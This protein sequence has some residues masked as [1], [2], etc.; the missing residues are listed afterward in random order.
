[1]YSGHGYRLCVSACLCIGL[2]DISA[3]VIAFQFVLE[4][5]I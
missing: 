5:Y 3:I 2:V 1:M 4:F